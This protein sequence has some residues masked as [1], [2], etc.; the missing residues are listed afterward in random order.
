MEQLINHLRILIDDKNQ[1]YAF[2]DAELK[3]AI[4]RYRHNIY[5]L[6]VSSDNQQGLIYTIG[7]SNISGVLTHN[8]NGEVIDS[9]DYSIDMLNGIIEFSEANEGMIYASFEYHDIEESAADM[10]LVQAGKARAKGAYRLG[11][12]SLP[13]GKESVEFCIQKSWE[14]RKSKSTEMNRS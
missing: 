5:K 3:R 2:G 4:N 6:P 14:F 7:Y 9:G 8:S 13:E 11:D 1:P 10:W 12:Q